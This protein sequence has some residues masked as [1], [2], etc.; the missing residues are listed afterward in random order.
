MKNVIKVV[1][2]LGLMAAALTF[3]PDI[4][5]S[6]EAPSASACDLATGAGCNR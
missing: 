6:V 4:K 5:I 1:A 2:V 3:A